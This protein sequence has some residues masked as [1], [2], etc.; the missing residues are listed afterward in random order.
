FFFW[1]VRA[2]FP[3]PGASLGLLPWIALAAA[4]TAWLLMLLAR[5]ANARDNAALFHGGV[6][7]AIAANAVAIYALIA[8]PLRAGL[9]PVSHV[10]PATVWV[11]AGWTVAHL[12]LGALMQAWCIAR[13]LAGRLDA[14]HDIDIAVCTLYWHFTA[15]T[16]LVTVLVLAGFPEL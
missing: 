1:T 15:I 11:L 12:A 5:H 10:Y 6:S 4:I 7:A 16:V 9:D 8:A 2:D 14:H 3:P 13:R